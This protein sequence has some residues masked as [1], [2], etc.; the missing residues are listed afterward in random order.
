MPCR[1]RQ[2]RGL[3]AV[4]LSPESVMLCPHWARLLC[5]SYSGVLCPEVSSPAL[6]PLTPRKSLGIR[7]SLVLS[8]LRTSALVTCPRNALPPDLLLM[9][10]F[11]SLRIECR[12]HLL[13]KVFPC[14]P[15]S[16]FLL[17]LFHPCPSLGTLWSLPLHQKFPT[18][19]SWHLMALGGRNFCGTSASD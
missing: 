16:S 11:L 6:C 15:S 5:P 8:C 7:G 17:S 2:D 18:W 19:G 13:R 4:C 12:T 14:H 10:F 3:R 9:A 1:W